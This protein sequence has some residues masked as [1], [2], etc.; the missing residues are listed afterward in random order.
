VRNIPGGF[1]QEPYAALGFVDPIFEHARRRDI[2][3]LITEI[4]NL[5][6]FVGE[7]QIIIAKLGQ[8]VVRRYELSVVVQDALLAVDLANRTDRRAT[9]LA[10][11]FSDIIGCREYRPARRAADDSRGS[12]ARTYANGSSL[13]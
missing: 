6:H 11:A 1:K 13:S 2:A 4:V 5:A 10:R 8:H 9:D 7:L 3:M 12:S